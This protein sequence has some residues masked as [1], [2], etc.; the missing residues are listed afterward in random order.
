MIKNMPANAG[1]SG[2]IPGS[3]RFPW[4]RKMANHS[5]ILAYEIPRTKEPAGLQS[6]GAQKRWNMT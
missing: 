1:D 2:S 6:M 5:S 3:E 4:R